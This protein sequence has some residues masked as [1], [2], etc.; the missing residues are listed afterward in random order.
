MSSKTKKILVPI[1]AILAGFVLGAIIMLIFGFNPIWGYEDLFISA[2]GNSRAIGETIQTAGPLI[3]TALAFAV[4]MKAGLF[5]IGM[6]GQALSGWLFSMWFALS[7]PD[8]PRVLMIPLVII[9]GMVFGALMGLI[10]GVLRA[11]LGTSEVITTIML[12]YVILYF[13][14]YVVHNMMAKKIIMSTSIDQTNPVSANATFRASWLSN[15][16]DNSTLNIGIFIALIAL[17]IMAVVF[18]KTTL[19]YEINAVGL[20]PDASEYAGISSKRTIIL[21]MVVA[22][23]L[24][25]LGGVVY[26]FGY[27]QNFV[28]QSSSLDIGFNG[29]AV[30]LL[31]GNNPIGILFA[32]LLFSVLQTGAPG[33][34]T[35]QIPPQIIQVVTASIIFFIAIKFVIEVIL[36]KTKKKG[37]KA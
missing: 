5:N 35:D 36:P 34:M 27:M 9:I 6:S 1:I 25:G 10:P 12:N 30:A 7:F 8:I 18:S 21:S 16:T 14:T 37:E 28:V 19:G 20:N 17:V 23:A 22:G 24:A 15:L 32:G 26:G 11:L 4:A 33:M 31:G 3:L 13:S 2:L 29:M